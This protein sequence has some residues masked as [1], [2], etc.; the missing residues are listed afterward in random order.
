MLGTHNHI[1]MFKWL[2]YM[3]NISSVVSTQENI[4]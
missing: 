1:L 2:A 4:A 3:E